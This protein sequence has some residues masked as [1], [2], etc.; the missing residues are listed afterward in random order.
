MNSP[1]KHYYSITPSRSCPKC[2][3]NINWQNFTRFIRSI[4]YR[5]SL[6]STNIPLHSL[7]EK[8]SWVCLEQDLISRRHSINN[9]K[10][11]R[12]TTFNVQVIMNEYSNNWSNNSKFDFSDHPKD[13][14]FLLRSL[15]NTSHTLIYI[16]FIFICSHI[17]E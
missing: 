4:F 8:F 3:A 6:F 15:L 11:L 1:V 10:I 2:M 7:Y 14:S 16:P 5:T 17:W 9:H 13:W 12:K